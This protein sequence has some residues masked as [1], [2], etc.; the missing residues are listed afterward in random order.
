M[1]TDCFIGIDGGGSKTRFLAADL[2]G[3]LYAEAVAGP[4]YYRQSGIAQVILAL[5]DG[6]AACLPAGRRAA[7]CFGMPG[8]GESPAEDG[9]AMREISAALSPHLVC[10]ENDVAAGW[11]GAFAL[12][13]GVS[14][15]GGTGAMSYGRDANGTVAR[16]G[17]WSEFFSD[18]G[19]GYWL[20]KQLLQLFSQQSDR[21]LPRTALYDLVRERLAL[22]ND[23]DLIS[24]AEKRFIP[25]RKETA[26]LQSILLEAAR[27]GDPFALASYDEAAKNLAGIL[28]GSINKLRF[29]EKTVPASYVGGLFEISDLIRD[30]VR[31]YAEAQLAPQ[32]LSF[33]PPLLSPC[34][35]AILLAAETFAPAALPAL[36]SRLLSRKGNAS[37]FP[38]KT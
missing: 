20:G 7:V 34:E 23:F 32:S 18:E 25:S 19:S 27:M 38:E 12:S 21:R 28:C 15:V 8:Y 31:R 33:A 26:A 16:C 5:R 4:T 24:L 17:G 14:I 35:G 13:P 36:R 10:F 3:A 37:A 30:P 1:R 9:A 29:P 22:Q 6:I 11:A 2:D